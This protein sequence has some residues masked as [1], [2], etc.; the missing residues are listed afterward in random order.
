MTVARA[1]RPFS[2]VRRLMLDR[3]HGRVPNRNPFEFT[4]PLEVER[5]FASLRSLEH[6]EWTAVFGALASERAERASRAEGRRDANAAAAPTSSA[7]PNFYRRQ[8]P[9]RPSSTASSQIC[10]PLLQRH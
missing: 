8:S 10:C 1:A 7:S 9:I 5:A 4:D 6:G 2:E 3:A